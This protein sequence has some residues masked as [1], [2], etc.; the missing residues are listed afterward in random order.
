MDVS[1]VTRM[2]GAPGVRV[3]WR[4]GQFFEVNAL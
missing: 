3:H 2:L 4:K 1:L